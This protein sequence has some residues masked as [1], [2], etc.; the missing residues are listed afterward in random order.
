MAYYGLLERT[1]KGRHESATEPLWVRRHDEYEAASAESRS[2]SP[3]PQFPHF[4]TASRRGDRLDS[5]AGRRG[6]AC[7]FAQERSLPPETG[8]CGFVTGSVA[9]ALTRRARYCV[10]A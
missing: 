9:A 2:G 8:A 7:A 10:R 3:L 6:G 1:P 4:P 5:T